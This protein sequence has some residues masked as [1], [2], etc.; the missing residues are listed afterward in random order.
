MTIHKVKSWVHL[1]RAHQKGP[2]S[3]W[4]RTPS[5]VEAVIA[6]REA[7]LKDLVAKQKQLTA[8]GMSNWGYFKVLEQRKAER[9]RANG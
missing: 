6:M 5:E 3:N 1:F 4:Y 7:E 2:I 8:K 9:S